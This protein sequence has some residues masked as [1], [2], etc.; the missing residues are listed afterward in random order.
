MAKEATIRMIHGD[1][2]VARDISL[3]TFRSSSVSCD[4]STMGLP[5]NFR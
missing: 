3:S 2:A 4:L 1:S 5:S